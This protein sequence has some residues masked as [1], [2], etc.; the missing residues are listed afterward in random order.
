LLSGTARD[1]ERPATFRDVLASG[2]FRAIYAASTLSWVGD[3]IAR[4]AI[5]A[6]VYQ[7][8]HSVTASAAA[9]AISYAPWLLGGSLL[10]SLA[11]R[12]PYRRVMVICDVG[13]TVI[14]GMVALLHLP[15]PLVLVLL[16]ASALFSPP[17]DAARSATLPSVLSGDRYVVGLAMNTAMA[18]PA[19]VAGY[20][21][22]ASL[23]AISPR[24][25]LLINAGTFAV[26]GL[27]LRYGVRWRPAALDKRQRSHLLNETVEGFRL[28]FSQP[29]LRS[30]ILLVFCGILFPVV[31]EGL[32]AA[33]A[34][35][36]ADGPNQGLAQGLIMGAVPLGAIFGALTITRLVAPA[37]RRRLL[38]PIALAVPLVLVPTLLDPPVIVVVA[39]VFLCGYAA[40]ALLP[41]ANGQFVQA[42]PN[43]F[44]ARAFGVVQ[45]GL[46]LVQG[47]AVLV[48]GALAHVGG[49]PLVIGL[50][51]L[52]GVGLMLLLSL[53]WPS[54]KVFSDAVAAAAS[55]NATAEAHRTYTARHTAAQDPGSADS[56]LDSPDQG[57]LVLGSPDNDGRSDESGEVAEPSEENEAAATPRPRGVRRWGAVT[58][59]ARKREPASRP[60]TMEP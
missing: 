54:P 59:A 1:P 22:G 44:R 24:M 51:G 41:I 32:G 3:Y 8:T 42:L 2:E 45:G 10:V 15:L 25:A 21:I 53:W 50:W 17:F 60:G 16:L 29:A 30:L 52:G 48:T 9:F 31:P 49:L 46:Q 37:T 55:A 7:S 26:S 5:T 34:A 13:R 19:Q 38:R 56:D 39:L 57:G 4:A 43:A 47:G 35:K 6:L 20:F 36:I 27:L 28:V 33:W 40:G 14:M 18:Q 11:E 12:Y 23:A 58:G